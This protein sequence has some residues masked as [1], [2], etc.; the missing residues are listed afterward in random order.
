ML[1]WALEIKLYKHTK[2]DQ[3]ERVPDI[4]ICV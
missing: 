3:N 2:Y 1:P 4:R